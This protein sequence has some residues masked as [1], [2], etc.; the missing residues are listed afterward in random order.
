M[1]LM[2]CKGETP[3]PIL[4]PTH[5]QPNSPPCVALREA[6]GDLEDT[7][8]HPEYSHEK[9]EAYEKLAPGQCWRH[10]SEED[11]KKYV[12]A[13]LLAN[14]G[15]GGQTGVL[16][17]LAYDKPCPA[18]VCSPSQNT[19]SFCHPTKTRPLSVEE[20]KRIQGFDDEY[21]IQGSMSAQYKQIGN[22]VPIAMSRA[23]ARAL[24]AHME[25]KLE[26]V[27][28]TFTRYKVKPQQIQPTL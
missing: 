25:D 14:K 19:T 1:I 2:A 13:G 23:I 4:K 7:G 26:T 15:R 10:L 27:D 11:Q 21:T 6:I 8:S 20:Y 3:I 28:G 18:L 9:K 12:G 16:R 17:R 22:A 24:R 5:G